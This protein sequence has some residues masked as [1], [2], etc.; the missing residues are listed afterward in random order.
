MALSPLAIT[1]SSWLWNNFGKEVSSKTAS[2]IK[3]RWEKFRW[4]DAAEEYKKKIRKLYGTMQI[5]GMYHAVPLDDIFTDAY[6]LDKPTALGRFSIEQMLA[7]LDAPPRRAARI[8]GLRLVNEKGN[9]FIL[10]K[11][12]AGKTTFLKYVAMR[13]AEQTI[14]KVPIFVSL[15]EWTD[16]GVELLPFIVQRFDT[17]GFP[18]AQPFVEE[19]L[20]SGSAIVLFDG[21]DEVSTDSG[22]RYKEAR[23]INNF[24]EKYDRAQCLITCRIA[25]TD[26][27]FQPFTYVEI[28]DFNEKQIRTFVGNWFRKEGEIDRETCDKFL[29]EFARKENKALRELAR[30]PLLLTLLCLAF[31]ETLTFPQ[32]RVEIYEEALDALLKKWDATRRIRRDN[33]YRKLSLGHKENMLAYIAANTFERNKYFVQQAELEALISDYV[34]N[35]PPHDTTHAADSEVILKTIEAHHG[36]FVERAREVYSFAHL[37]FQEYFTAKYIVANATKSSLTNLVKEHCSEDRWREVFLLTTSLLPDG[38]HFLTTFR[39]NLDKLIRPHEK[40]RLM[41]EW[42][43]KKSA[44]IQLQPWLAR[45]TYLFVELQGAGTSRSVIDALAHAL[46]LARTSDSDNVLRQDYTSDHKLALD[47][48]LASIL[49]RSQDVF[50]D[51]NR[52]CLRAQEYAVLVAR[53]LKL[54]GLAKELTE[55]P[56]PTNRASSAE[57]Q[58]FSDKLRALILRHRDI[59]HEWGFTESEEARLADYVKATHLLHDCLQLAFMPPD[60]KRAMLDSLYVPPRIREEKKTS[61]ED[62]LISKNPK[63][64]E[65]EL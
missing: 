24:V 20:K 29:I 12:G 11:P 10:G 6:M 60:E 44:L 17:C 40:L 26:H 61:P 56:I 53:D 23:A 55:L 48:A 41:L 5:M 46:D 52:V 36:I 32:R 47:Y 45:P 39:Q 2:A 42:A 22:E 43:C 9:L 28:A 63:Q 13:C 25:A 27:S 64:F 15:K 3:H 59:R 51:R 4:N 19:L 50:F 65:Q 54:K 7:D 18:D 49:N 21:L 30:T 62:D 34:K 8:N 31:D 57:W 33:P 37:T 14:N 1:A 16:S 35:V 58:V 38:S